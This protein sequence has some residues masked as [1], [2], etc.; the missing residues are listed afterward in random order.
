MGTIC[1]STI[2][3]TCPRT[4]DEILDWYDNYWDK[5][6]ICRKQFLTVLEHGNYGD[7]QILW[8]YCHENHFFVPS[9]NFWLTR[10]GTVWYTKFAAH[11]FLLE[12]LMGI[13]RECEVESAGWLRISSI[14]NTIGKYTKVL[15]IAKPSRKQRMF[16]GKMGIGIPDNLELIRSK[17]YT[18]IDYFE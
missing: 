9:A 17:L 8:N 11:G 13:T 7:Y 16:L 18:P 14:G 4:K 10:K 3:M 15:G 1:V 5:N 2:P 12:F 6:G